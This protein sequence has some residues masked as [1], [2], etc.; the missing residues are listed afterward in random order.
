MIDAWDPA[1][2]DKFR[3]E[4]EQPF[5]DLLELIVARTGMRV[6]D[7]GCGTGTLTRVLHEQLQARETVGIDRSDRMLAAAA[8]GPP[9]AGLHFEAGAIESFAAAPAS[10]PAWDIIFSNAA[11]HWIDDHE[12][13]I[14]RLAALLTP[15]GQLAFQIPAQHDTLTHRIAHE[16]AG[17]EPFASALSG[18]VRSQPV[19]TPEGYAQVLHRCGFIDPKVR[20]IVYPH[21]LAGREEAVEWVKG[22]LLT[23]YQ[24]HLPVHLYDRFVDLYRER[25]LT[26]LEDTMPFF[27]P[28]KRILCWGRR[29]A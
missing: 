26:R 19:L 17:L 5:R 9:A 21:I 27:Y 20:L 22:T 25:L 28:F 24:R 8:A 4:R 15:T 3:R 6:V 18:W 7:L 11:L 12:R 16:V 10:A 13:L 23:D 14:P 2:Y 1:Q 29:S